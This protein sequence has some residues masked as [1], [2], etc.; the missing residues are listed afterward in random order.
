MR[1]CIQFGID[2][3][4]ETGCLP[5][6]QLCKELFIVSFILQKFLGGGD[7]NGSF[8]LRLWLPA[9]YRMGRRGKPYR[10][11]YLII[12]VFLRTLRIQ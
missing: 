9:S 2:D 4:S 3:H 8:Q 1:N 7:H 11:C 6:I 5:C 12:L 10:P